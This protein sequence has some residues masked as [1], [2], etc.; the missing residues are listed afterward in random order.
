MYK[1]INKSSLVTFKVKGRPEVAKALSLPLPATKHNKKIVKV[2]KLPILFG[3][4]IAAKYFENLLSKV[5]K[6]T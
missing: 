5:S 3:K 2:E 4:F 6:V 1:Y